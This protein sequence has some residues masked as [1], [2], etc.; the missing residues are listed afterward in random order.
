MTGH[1]TAMGVV[2]GTAAYMSP[3]QARGKP[4]DRRAD[5]WAFGAVLYEMLS[6]RRLFAGDTARRGADSGFKPAV[7]SGRRP[8]SWALAATVLVVIATGVGGWINW[9]RREHLPR[10]PVAPGSRSI[11]VLPFVNSSGNAEDEYLADGMTDELISGLGKVPGLRVAARSSAF[12]FKGGIREVAEKLSVDSVL[13]GTVRRSGKRLRVTASLV[14]AA[15]GLQ[16]WT[17][18]FESDGGDPFAVQD[19]VTH[20]VVSGLSLQL[21]GAALA[22][23]QAGRTSDP[24][25]HDLYLRGLQAAQNAASEADL[26]RALDFYRQALARDPAFAL[27]YAGIAVVHIYLADAYVAPNEAYPMVRAAA[28]AALERDSHLAE[29][30]A[31]KAFAAFFLDWDWATADREFSRALELN[32]NSVDTLLFSGIYR[33]VGHPDEGLAALDRAARLDPLS[34]LPRFSQE[35]CSYFSGR[36]S[37]VI[38]LHRKTQAL[39]PSFVYIDSWVGGAYRELGDYEAAMREYKAAERLLNG[40]PQYGLALTYEKLG[41]CDDARD[42]MRRLDERARTHYVP[43]LLRAAVHA[44]LG[45]MNEAVTLLQRAVDT[46]EVFVHSFRLLPEMAPLLHDARAQRIFAQADA[47]RKMK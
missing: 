36:Y 37:A 42:V 2:I 46:R 34:P 4:V 38:E 5:V 13:E 20:G 3:E 30:H 44:G 35:F 19:E 6:G 9:G 12:S 29:A 40:V 8:R 24:E 22:A 26:R 25:A 27:A 33:C 28:E 10:L 14:S 1:A 15:D 21:G 16:I 47:L 39:A 45:D 11:A 7:G 23:S 18:T 43:Y 32:P 41:R 17:S 31:A